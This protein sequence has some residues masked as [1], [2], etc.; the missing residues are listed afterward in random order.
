[1]PSARDVILKHIDAVNGH[2]SDADPQAARG[3]DL[4]DGP[5]ASPQMLMS[6]TDL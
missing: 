3:T 4:R 1:M 6:V 5:Y 2:D